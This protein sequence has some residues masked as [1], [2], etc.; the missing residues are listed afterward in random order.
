MQ[1][2]E[3][4]EVNVF[5]GSGGNGSYA[6]NFERAKSN[7]HHDWL[8]S[9]P[10]VFLFALIL[11]SCGPRLASGQQ[12]AANPWLGV[13]VVQKSQDFGL[14]IENQ[15]VER[16]RFIL[17]YKVEQVS[18]DWLWLRAEGKGF[19][20]WVRAD[21]VVPVDKALEYFS[22]RIRQNPSDA[23]A[24]MMRATVRHDKMQLNQAVDDYNQAIKLDPAHAWVF[25]NRGIAWSDLKDYDQALADFNEAIRLD[26]QNANVYNNR[27]TIWRKKRVFHAAL[28]DFDRAIQ[29]Q[30]R[31][32]FAY[33]NRGLTWADQKDYVK[34]AADFDEVIR[35]FPDDALSY[36]NR[37]IAHFHLKEFDK[38]IADDTVAIRL[39]PEQR[40]C[41]LQPGARLV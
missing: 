32:A 20:G 10:A 7:T 5:A 38:A 41:L 13:R 21:D 25:N 34:A 8:K 22:E 4:F 39:D 35:I 17:F 16:R 24:Y 3:V 23:F 33:Y 15:V 1:E 28:A 31:Y 36:Y 6:R 37:A 40:G 29:L 19:R 9:R 27:G 14:K 26:T 12:P 2:D 30:P 11:G 18:G